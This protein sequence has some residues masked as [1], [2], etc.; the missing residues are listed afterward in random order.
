MATHPPTLTQP[1]TTARTHPFFI[2]GAGSHNTST[3]HYWGT[4]IWFRG[5]MVFAS[6]FLALLKKNQTYGCGGGRGG[7]A[8]WVCSCWR[9]RRKQIGIGLGQDGKGGEHGVRVMQWQQDGKVTASNPR[10]ASAAS[11]GGGDRQVEERRE[12]KVSQDRAT[13]TRSKLRPPTTA[14]QKI[15]RAEKG[16]I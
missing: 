4:L 7:C 8:V 15:G 5:L 3:P 16:K 1:T 9:E 2:P 10:P 14:I 12:L 11:F 6:S 13:S